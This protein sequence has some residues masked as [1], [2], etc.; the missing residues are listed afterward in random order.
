MLLTE[1][2]YSIL[3]A[4]D[5]K[6]LGKI[7]TLFF[8]QNTNWIVDQVEDGVEA[9]KKIEEREYDLLLTDI[10]M[11]NMN[12]YELIESIKDKD[13]DMPIIIMTANKMDNKIKSD[14][15]SV[16]KNIKKCI[17]K[18]LK[19]SILNELEE[20]ILSSKEKNKDKIKILIA[21]DDEVLGKI[22]KKLI[23][24]VWQADLVC[25]GRDALEKLK[26]SNIVYS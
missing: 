8:M 21:E 14:L 10:N 15:K 23:T 7:I 9:I 6:M 11:P 2:I 3:V 1:D 18:P 26:V 22:I 13:I 25:N 4:E 5:D 20:I 17:E 24:N 19:K 16:N 12:G